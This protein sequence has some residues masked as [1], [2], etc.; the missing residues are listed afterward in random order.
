MRRSV[1]LTTTA[2]RDMGLLARGQI[3]VDIF[4]ADKRPVL[5]PGESYGSSL[6]SNSVSVSVLYEREAKA[7]RA[8]TL[9]DAAPDGSGGRA[10]ALDGKVLKGLDAGA[11]NI[12]MVTSTSFH[13]LTGQPLE[14]TRT[15][16]RKAWQ[17]GCGDKERLATAYARSRR[18]GL[19][20]PGGAWDLLRG[21]PR[22]TMHLADFERYLGAA[23][24]AHPAMLEEKLKQWWARAS[25]DRW[26][27]NSS[28]LV[29]FYSGCF[30]GSLADGDLGQPT[31]LLYGDGG[32]GANVSTGPG[33]QSSPSTGAER[34]CLTAAG[35][36]RPKGGPTPMYLSSEFRSTVLCGPTGAEP[37]CWE[38]LLPV[39]ALTPERVY[40]AQL[41]RLA[42]GQEAFGAARPPPPLPPQWR[43][44]RGK[45]LCGNPLCKV[46]FVTRDRHPGR[47]L[48]ANE[49]SLAC[50]EGG[51]PGMQRS[52]VVPKVRFPLGGFLLLPPRGSS[53]S[54]AL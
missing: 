22:K 9:A 53:S 43:K 1:A 46:G 14:V 50:G 24:I 7:K 47:A 41:A 10:A 37:G 32:S 17:S 35:A 6:V 11:T 18:A 52:T 21:T 36:R 30:A 20:A 27:R 19:M 51:V 45:Q 54:A 48:I 34:A 44:V 13:P 25:F 33:R 38:R 4:H 49:L 16:T 28:T 2:L 5:R 23:H 40:R 3:A 12:A 26:I 31:V 15:L 29:G 42:R 8:G 39:Y